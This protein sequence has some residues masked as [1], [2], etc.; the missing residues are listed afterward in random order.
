MF[1]AR[2]QRLTTSPSRVKYA[3][4]KCQNKTLNAFQCMHMSSCIYIYRCVRKLWGSRYCVRGAA[5]V[6]CFSIMVDARR[7]I[8]FIRCLGELPVK[9][10][11]ARCV[12]VCGRGRAVGARLEREVRTLVA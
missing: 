10:S 7:I 8:E 3:P 2:L 1:L 6:K 9:R 5:E 4:V 12:C 11:C